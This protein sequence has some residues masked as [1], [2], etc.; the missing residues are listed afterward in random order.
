MF[1]RE[2]LIAD[3]TNIVWALEQIAEPNTCWLR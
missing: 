1:D 2:L 3:I